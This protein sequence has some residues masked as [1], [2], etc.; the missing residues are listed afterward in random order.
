MRQPGARV[1]GRGAGPP[2]DGPTAGLLL[3]GAVLLLLLRLAPAVGDGATEAV[4]ADGAGAA[5]AVPSRAEA[6]PSPES[7]PAP[8]GEAEG[9]RRAPES[10][11]GLPAAS[12]RPVARRPASPSRLREASTSDG[13]VAPAGAALPAAA[14]PAPPL[15]DP[16]PDDPR[17]VTVSVSGRAAAGAET[18][19][20]WSVGRD[21]AVALART[22]AD[23]A[24]RFAF[25]PV[26]RS[27]EEWRVTVGDDEPLREGV[28]LDRAREEPPAPVPLGLSPVAG[29]WRLRLAPLRAGGVVV[30]EDAAGRE[31]LRR[32]VAVLPDASRRVLEVE[33]AVLGTGARLRVSQE[34]ASGIRT[35]WRALAVPP[36]AQP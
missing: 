18:L 21:G 22:R 20:L 28:P 2:L 4:A 15:L 27:G 17:A 19:T 36:P 6:R 11:R 34:D 9:G 16:L 13:P 5:A 10:G 24:G 31:L 29:G 35:G 25:A 1:A 23:G 8:G 30:L 32:P 14:S 3:A 33:L 26:P 7:P 12:P